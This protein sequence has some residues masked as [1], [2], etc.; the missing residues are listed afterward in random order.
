M[1]IYSCND[2]ADGDSVLIH[3]FCS[4]MGSSS[5]SPI[6]VNGVSIYNK[7]FQSS[8]NTL[9]HFETQVR[10][11]VEAKI[12]NKEM[13]S[14]QHYDFTFEANFA[15]FSETSENRLNL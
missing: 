9:F 11:Y 6:Y 15:T 7:V 10:K 1:I 5:H 13:S 3:H 2:Y 4:G 14:E 12:T 8:K